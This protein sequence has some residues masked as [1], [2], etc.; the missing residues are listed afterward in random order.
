MLRFAS[1]NLTFFDIANHIPYFVPSL[2]FVREFFSKESLLTPV[3][4]LCFA[5]RTGVF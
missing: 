3:F 1:Q 2:L 5:I 4:Y